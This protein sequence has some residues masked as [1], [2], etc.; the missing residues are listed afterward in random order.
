MESAVEVLDRI[1]EEDETE[2]AGIPKD[3]DLVA[4]L[5]SRRQAEIIRV[6]AGRATS[7]MLETMGGAQGRRLGR[8]DSAPTSTIT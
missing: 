8:C 6:L 2:R 7:A 3:P 5:S 4:A 1:L